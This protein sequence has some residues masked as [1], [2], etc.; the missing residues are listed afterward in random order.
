MTTTLELRYA[1][2]QPTSKGD[3]LQP[4]Y[5]E[6]LKQVQWGD[7]RG[8]T[9]VMISEHH[10]S[11]DSY[12]SSPMVIGGAIAALTKNIRVRIASLVGPLHNPVRLAEDLATLDILLNGRLEPVVSGGYVGSEFEAMGTS[13]S[14][15][16]DY[17]EAIIPFLNN[18]WS[19]EEFEW[20][21]KTICVRPR[22]VQRPMP[23]Y[24]GG[25]SNV[26][27]RRAARHGAYFLPALPKFYDA[28]FDEWDKTGRPRPDFDHASKYLMC[29][30]A[31][32][33]E[34]FWHDYGPS[35]L[36][37]N[38]AYAHWAVTWNTTNGYNY[39]EDV[40][41]LREQGFYPLYT[42]DEVVAKAKEMGPGGRL[43]F[44]PMA[45]G[46]DPDLAWE[47]LELIESKVMPRLA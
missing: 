29:W 25:A 35:L 2:R 24:M 5:E 26:A 40:N 11:P 23:I 30:V 38:N 4:R 16:K 7:E 1:L 17:M 27:A 36:H 18:A 47:M 34:K 20:Q 19:G 12:M 21:G 22:P 33:K 9:H 28:Y 14:A 43:Q 8:F 45:G 39:A 42:P 46:T 3:N 6:F 41:Q 32:D 44:H 10:G 31:E 37:E 13:L 15:R